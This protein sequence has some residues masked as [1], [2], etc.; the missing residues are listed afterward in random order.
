M[1]SYG[2]FCPVAKA[3]EV[4]CQ[5]WNALIIRDLSWGSSTYSELKRGVPM[6]SPALLTKRLR[7]LEREGVIERRSKKSSRGFTYHL[8]EAG[9]EFA[10]IIDAMGAWGRRWTRRELEDDEIDMDLLL[11]GLESSARFDAF[12][13]VPTVIQIDFADQPA[14]KQRWWF[15]ND[16]GRC[17][18]CVD[19][20][21]YE[22]DVFLSGKTE[23]FIHV[24]LGDIS[25]NSALNN[26]LLEA[27]G[28]AS[29]I[30]KLEAWLNPGPL[31]KVASMREA[32]VAND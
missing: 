19:Y 21:G 9:L 32:I 31:S 29:D 5:R 12:G 23:D 10:P 14:N 6:M 1:R 27:I 13:R 2:Q 15:L 16:D 3:A 22:V 18:L 30:K 20:P 17:Q 11:W 7:D 8:T 25:L 28:N 24:Y 4:F 26:E